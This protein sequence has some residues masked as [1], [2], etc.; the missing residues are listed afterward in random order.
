[1]SVQSIPL[2]DPA[3]MA[4]P[5]LRAQWRQKGG[6]QALQTGAVLVDGGSA[7]RLFVAAWAAS[8]PTRNNLPDS[9]ANPDGTGTSGFWAVFR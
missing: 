6:L 4:T 3:G 9:V 8:F 2:F 5:F 7:T 1:M